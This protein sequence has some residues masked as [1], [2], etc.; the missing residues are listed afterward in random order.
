M[1]IGGDKLNIAVPPF[2]VASVAKLSKADRADLSALQRFMID[3]HMGSK[4]WVGR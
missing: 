4:S 3:P 2:A 1:N